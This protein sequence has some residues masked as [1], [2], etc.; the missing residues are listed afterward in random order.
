MRYITLLFLSF[1]CTCGLASNLSAQCT[2]DVNIIETICSDAGGPSFYVRFTVEG[3]GDS[4]WTSPTFNVS[5]QYNTGFIYTV[6]PLPGTTAENVLFQDDTDGACFTVIDRIEADCVV[7]DCDDFSIQVFQEEIFFCET[8]EIWNLM[9][10]NPNW[11]VEVV[12][13]SS[14]GTVYSRTLTPLSPALSEFFDIGFYEVIMTD[15]NGCTAE[16]EF[17]AEPHFCSSIVGRSWRDDNNNG[18]Q[19]PGEDVPVDAVV[20]LIGTTGQPN[21]FAQVD[22][23]NG[24]IFRFDNLQEGEYRMVIE[25]GEGLPLTFFQEGDDRGADSDFRLNNN[26]TDWFFLQGGTTETNYDAGWAVPQCD[27]L[28]A[29]IYGERLVCGDAE[30]LVVD[31]LGPT[32]PI[33]V[34]LFNATTNEVDSSLV[35][36]APEM[37][38]FEDLT[39]GPYR[40]SL[41]DSD[42]CNNSSLFFVT[43]FNGLDVTIFQEGTSCFGE[44]GITLTAEAFGSDGV[45]YSY[46]WSN[47]ATTQSISNVVGGEFYWVLVT[48]PI[49]GCEGEAGLDVFNDNNDSLSFFGGEFILPCDS[50]SVLVEP[51]TIIAGF[52]YQWF[53]QQNEIIDSPSF[54]ASRTGFYQLRATNDAGCAITGWASVISNDL[55]DHFIEVYEYV[56]D[57][58]CTEQTCFGLETTLSPNSDLDFTILWEGPSDEFN[59]IANQNPFQFICTPE[60]GLYQLTVTTE[61]DT[62]VR[63]FFVEDFPGCSSISGSLWIDQAADCDLDA[64]DTAVPSY[65]IMLTDLTGDVYYTISDAQGNWSADLPLGTYV[66]EPTLNVGAPFGTCSPPVSVTLG[67]SPVTGIN[68]F[69]PVTDDCPQLTTDVSMPFLRR[70]FSSNAWVEYEN[71]GAVTAEDAELVVTLDDFFV[72][73][74]A[75]EDFTRDGN[76]LI[77]QLG[78]LPPF[79]SGRILLF[80]VV[81]CDAV[82]GQAH[83]VEANIKP[84]APCGEVENWNGALVTV[85]ALGC[86]GDS[87]TFLVTNIGDEQMSVPLSYIIVED[88]IML[89]PTPFTN[90]LLAPNEAMPITV[91]ATGGTY[92]VITNQ[93]PNAPAD[94]MPTAV[95]EGC[96]I[97]GGNTFTTGFTNILPLQNG[98]RTTTVVCRENVGS[99]DPNDK[100]GYPLGFNGNNIHEGTRLDYA[101]RFQNT[102]TDTAFTVVIRDT[103]AESLDLATLK[104]GASSHDYTATLDT[105]RVLTFVF[106]NILLPDSSRNLAGSQGVVNFSID[107]DPSLVSGDVIL[108]DAA[109]YFD[110]NEP[111]LTNVSRHVIAKDGLPV[112]TRAAFAQQV[113]LSVFPS[114]TDGLLNVRMPAAEA[115]ADDILTVTDLYGRELSRTNYASAANGWNLKHLPAGYYLLLLLDDAGRARGRAG[116][117]KQ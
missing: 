76:T 45:A 44:D 12:V 3:N 102:G 61:C 27:S 86:D 57:S 117:V 26:S 62:V 81:S 46:L 5:G 54:Y 40:V 37:L 30:V 68:I 1:L 88:G 60:P 49:N 103:I 96:E 94:S 101:I 105:H 66:I 69:L 73:V 72:N 35:V 100:N 74:T 114:P 91:P 111:I 23:A 15:A 82:L 38:R 106:E 51:D 52:T 78:D 53:G 21:Q 22:V 92:H 98:Q 113:A 87:V 55:D 65:V 43:E 4:L 48:D 97:I 109:I 7:N 63:S 14:F 10:L 89:S 31:V 75:N 58:A 115:S 93:E 50:D 80:F 56:Q 83:C 33:T 17:F 85:D 47:G 108:N 77:F 8:G 6:G 107:H 90:G 84:D 42:G 67:N 41:S 32:F 25:G 99:Y 13:T 34:E 9:P 20:T 79:S 19:D 104:L 70:C 16:T 36:D 112:S 18:L 71:V 116:F 24:G 11:P 28:V 39:P 59:Q 95:I 110:F 64:E 2:I 29:S